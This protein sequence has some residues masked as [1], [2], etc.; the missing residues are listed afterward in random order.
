MRMNVITPEKE[1]ETHPSFLMARSAVIQV[2]S[3]FNAAF[4]SAVLTQPL[5]T[6][7]T[8]LQVLGSNS[9]NA[10]LWLITKE[11]ASKGNLY[12]ALLPRIA[13]MGV[14]GSVLSSAYEYLKVVSRKDECS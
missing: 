9:S 1:N 11:L 12:Q 10:S 13:H 2:A 7:K 5:D 14:W 3:A 4:A 8:R 6:I